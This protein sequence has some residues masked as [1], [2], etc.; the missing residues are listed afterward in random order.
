M[1]LDKYALYT[2][3]VQDPPVL[4]RFLHAV[5]GG[6]PR[7]LRE[8]FSGPAAICGAWLDVVTRGS[9]FAVDRDAAP[10]SRAR[11]DP[12]L[13]TIRR[14][15]LAEPR[16]ADIIAALNFPVGYWH[17]RAELV[18]YLTLSRKRLKPGGVLV[19]DMYG[20]SDAF[21]PGTTTRRL[22]GP[23]GERVLY[24]WEQ[25]DADALTGLVHNAIHFTVT[26]PPAR[27][28]AASSRTGRTSSAPRRLRRA[29][30]YH[31]RLWSIPELTDAMLDA[32]FD[33]VDVYDRLGDA[34]DSEGRLYVSPLEPGD[35]LDPNWVA[36]LAARV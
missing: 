22:R 11:K 32:G 13:T 12:R 2:L 14:D 3:C 7:T 31:W 4:A 20:G 1:P 10:L 36:Y 19:C 29:F 27:K 25:I 24:E 23:G 6:E 17:T 5:H 15:V 35:G 26:P 21:T 28:T 16:K 33:R 30:T 8:D 9:A 18:T 34:V